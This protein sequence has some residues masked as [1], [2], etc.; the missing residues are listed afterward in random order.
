MI[1]TSKVWK[2]ILVLV[3]V[4][5]I[6]LSELN[7]QR[8]FPNAGKYRTKAV[9]A[10]NEAGT[11]Y[12]ELNFAEAEKQLERAL[13]SEPSFIEAWLLYGDVLRDDGRK[14]DALAA[15]R[16]A[17]AIDSAFFPPALFFAGDL[18]LGA[19]DYTGA[20]QMFEKFLLSE[21]IRPEIQLQALDRLQNARFGINALQ[22][23]RKD[24]LFLLP[25]I[26]NSPEDEYVNSLSFDDQLLYFTRRYGNVATTRALLNESFFEAKKKDGQFTQLGKLFEG[27]EFENRVGALSFAADGQSVYFASCDQPEGLG[28]CDLYVS[29]FRRGEWSAPENLGWN[30]NSTGW[31]SQPCISADGSELYFVSRRK[32]GYGGSDLWKV[33]RLPGGDWSKAINLGEQLN[34]QGNEMAPFLHPDGHHLYFSTTGR[35]GMGGADLFVSKLDAAGRWSEPENL[36]YPIN[37]LSDE[38]NI[39]FNARGDE[40]FLSSNRPEGHGG[41]DLFL[42]KTDPVFRPDA[43]VFL[44]LIVYD[45]LTKKP[46]KAECTLS[47]LGQNVIRHSG[48]SDAATGN[49]LGLLPAGSTYALSVKSDGYCLYTAHIALVSGTQKEPYRMEIGL[50]AIETGSTLVLRNVFF[51][52]DKALLQ[53]ESF[54]ELE[55]LFGFLVN[56]PQLSIEL[57]GHTDQT[58][59]EAYNRLLSKQRAEAVCNY[60][61]SK[62]IASERLIARGY[63]SS[64]T[65][66]DNHTEEGRKLNRRTEIKILS[67]GNPSP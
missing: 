64:Q 19:G 43:V 26:V 18:M 1:G 2:T 5:G 55:Q 12:L 16:Q 54:P 24:S 27:R 9:Q 56:N 49:Y 28:S 66:A 34:S 37:T 50:Q 59:S 20:E 33:V 67:N 46:I 21:G 39:V 29:W 7:A 42:V 45:S 48:F 38:L 6:Y 65:V 40:A 25:E 32:G 63:G 62:G 53:T 8:T 51:E 4:L 22:Y 44:Q 3:F 41:F 57:S 35:P 23:P 10:F 61:I 11:A 52:T 31:D 58:G 36:A 13:R 14:A 47:S 17:L 60:L 15:Y 30:V